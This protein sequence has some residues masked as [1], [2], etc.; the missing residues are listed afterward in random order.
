MQLQLGQILKVNFA[1][2]IA[3][4]SE[5]VQVTAESPLIDVKQNAASAS[6]QKDI[7]DLIPKGRDFTSVVTTAPG[8]QQRNARRRHQHRRVQRLRE[9]LHRRRAGHDQCPDGTAS[10]GRHPPATSFRKCR[11]SRAATTR[12]SARRPAASSAP[13]RAAARTRSMARSGRTTRQ[14]PA[15]RRLRQSSRLNPLNPLVAQYTTTARDPGQV[16]EPVA[17]HRRADPDRPSLVFCGLRSAARKEQ[18]DRHLHPEPRGRPADV[19][20]QPGRSQRQLQHHGAAHEQ[21]APEVRGQSQSDATGRPLWRFRV[22]SRTTSR[23]RPA[24]WATASR[25][26]HSGRAPPTRRI[27]RACSTPNQFNNR[28]SSI[29]DWVVSPKLYLSLTAGY[30]GYGSRGQTLTE[31]NTKTRRT[32]SQSNN[33]FPKFPRTCCSRTATRTASPTRAP[34][35]T[36]TRGS[37]STPTPRTTRTGRASTRSRAACSSSGSATTSTPASRPRT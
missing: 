15:P 29:T 21:P 28:Y 12:N 3:G 36:T 9:P 8:H 18:A 24:C 19:F 17:T 7:I 1:L 2:Q 10:R 13:S 32:F 22:W 23:R 37:A 25:T 20:E 33:V 34:R 27:F 31:F 30:L 5:A 11:S 26:P 4:V 14:R 6:I 16:V 35:R